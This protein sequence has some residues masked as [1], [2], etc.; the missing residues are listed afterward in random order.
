MPLDENTPPGSNVPP[1]KGGCVPPLLPTSPPDFDAPPFHGPG[2]PPPLPPTTKRHSVRQ[3][4]GIL[5]SLCL[6][7][8]LADAAVSVMDDSLILIFGVHLL[9]SARGI[10]FVFATLLAILVYC[11]MGLTPMIPKRL[12]LP[13]TLFGLAAQLAL[14][15]WLIYFYARLQQLIWGLSVFQLLFGLSILCWLQGGFKVRWPLVP[16]NRL[17]TRRFSWVNLSVF[18]LANVLVLLPALA[19]YVVFCSALAVDHF[20]DGFLA[21]RPR[22]F[23]VQ[24]R[25]YVRSDGKTILLAPMAHVGEADF[26]R[27]LSESFPTNSMILMEGVTDEKNLLTNK[28][29]YKRMAASL[30]LAEQ[31]REFKPPQGQI[32]QADLDIEE[33]TTTTIDFL[34]LIML[35]HTRGV[36]AG[37]LLKVAQYSPPP[38]F[39]EHL[40][41]DLVKKRNR[42]LL[43]EINARL[44]QSE[45]IIVP[46]GAA[47]IPE[48]AKEIQ[49]AGF[50]LDQS[51]DYMVIRFRLLSKRSNSAQSTGKPSIR[52]NSPE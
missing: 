29:S 10:V 30:G 42:H 51:R 33:F 43:E 15:P 3:L 39:Q 50:R 26:Y 2:D 31:Q 41:D 12:F 27:K 14:L 36:S 46:W 16:E 48:I 22:G 7:L 6:A 34:N 11:L 9:G 45:N 13:L 47:H 35:I 32:V 40:L 21:L 1:P 49:K 25:K 4:L 37:N 23:T 5:L 17:G 38:D 44:S 19:A 18:L 8:F 20:S 24:V 52:T 28:I